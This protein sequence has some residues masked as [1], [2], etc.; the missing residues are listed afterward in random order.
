[1]PSFIGLLDKRSDTKERVV[2]LN[3]QRK[4][5]GTRCAGVAKAFPGQRYAHERFVRVGRVDVDLFHSLQI[6]VEREMLAAIEIELVAFLGI[7]PRCLAP[8]ADA[9]VVIKLAAVE[10]RTPR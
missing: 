7:A 10:K 2:L 3:A 6:R 8:N 4:S 9:D 5:D 1:E